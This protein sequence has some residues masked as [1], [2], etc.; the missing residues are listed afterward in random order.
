MS[1]IIL[2]WII[3]I[4]QSYMFRGKISQVLEDIRF[5]EKLINRKYYSSKY[6]ISASLLTLLNIA[7]KIFIIT[8]TPG[9]AQDI[10]WLTDVAQMI[11][12]LYFTN[13]PVLVICQYSVFMG[14][15]SNQLEQIRNKM[16][17]TKVTQHIHTYVKSHFMLCRTAAN[18]N[19]I[20]NKF[21]LVQLTLPFML[22]VLKVYSAIVCIVKPD[23]KN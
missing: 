7:H 6:L 5:N 4:T 17:T 15:I 16:G 13:A 20:Y 3:F 12:F 8:I 10:L 19:S 9:S 22:A 1:C 14:I 23:L 18:I 21:L 11:P 2:T